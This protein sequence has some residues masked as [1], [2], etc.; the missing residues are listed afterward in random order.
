MPEQLTPSIPIALDRQRF[1]KCTL[2]AVRE[3]KSTTGVNP[4]SGKPFIGTV[5]EA[6]D[7]DGNIKTRVVFDPDRFSYVLAALLRD[8][9]SSITPE[10]A[11]GLIDS[12]PK[13]RE[14]INKCMQA[15]KDFL[16]Q[17]D[18]TDSI[19]LQPTEPTTKTS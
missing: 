3:M 6:T 8:D 10:I 14:S 5:E 11:E 16:G 13:F 15:I 18:E 2:K 17:E 12:G 1:L 9:D 4:F 19:P 7:K